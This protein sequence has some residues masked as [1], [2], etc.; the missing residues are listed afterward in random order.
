[1]HWPSYHSN[2]V[3]VQL[4]VLD[5]LVDYDEDIDTEAIEKFIEPV[6]T[7]PLRSQPGQSAEPGTTGNVLRDLMLHSSVDRK[8]SMALDWLVAK[9]AHMQASDC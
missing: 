7:D 9:A 4:Y 5:E 3:V 6:T 2:M 1:M 8:E